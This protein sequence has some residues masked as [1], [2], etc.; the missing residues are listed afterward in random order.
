MPGT[1]GAFDRAPRTT[2]ETASPEGTAAPDDPLS[3]FEGEYDL[4]PRSALPDPVPV[5][6]REATSPRW[7]ALGLA[8]LAIAQ[9]PIVGLWLL[10]IP[11]PGRTRT[12]AGKPA[13]GLVDLDRP[14]LPSTP[15]SPQ[16]GTIEV[17][18]DSPGAEIT[19]D[20][21][22]R[23]VSPLSVKDVGAGEHV[24]VVRFPDGTVEQTV[25]VEPGSTASLVVTPAALAPGALSGS[26]S[27]S[28]PISLLVYERGRLVGTTDVA[29]LRL[30]V[31]EHTLDLI[32]AELG[33][34]ARR[35]VR[36][37]PGGVTAVRLDLPR[38]PVSLE[39]DPWAEVWVNGTRVG[40]TPLPNLS[41]PI[42]RYEVTFRHPELGERS[43]PVLVT[44]EEPA[45]VR[46]SMTQAPG[47][48]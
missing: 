27:F 5:E 37:T 34:R 15:S 25:R 8:L 16:G 18:T 23:G 45:R 9:A 12:P 31:G 20:G 13:A 1:S 39:A 33:F 47:N 2:T 3:E 19:I 35:T 6:A 24:V 36:V 32:E 14:L 7:A 26:V 10:G 46:V 30:P 11:P 28:V 38:A 4:L 22:P 42:G 17:T 48:P 21:L 41:W 40:E 44:L 29:R 43:T